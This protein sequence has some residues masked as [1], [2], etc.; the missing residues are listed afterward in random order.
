MR[1]K[2]YANTSGHIH[3][4]RV[5]TRTTCCSWQSSENCSI[6]NGQTGATLDADAV[7]WKVVRV[8]CLSSRILN[9]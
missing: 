4:H 7:S 6:P 5:L 9:E 3:A 8:G 1:N 2:L